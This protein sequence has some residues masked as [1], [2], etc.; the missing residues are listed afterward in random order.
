MGGTSGQNYDISDTTGTL[1]SG[2]R[3]DKDVTTIVGTPIPSGKIDI[4]GVIGQYKYSAPYNNGYQ[5]F[6][7]FISDIIDYG[8][9]L[10]LSPV[11]AADIDTNTFTVYFTT[12]RNGDTKIKYGLTKSLELD[13]LVINNDTTKHVVKVTGLLSSKTYYYRVYS[14]NS[15]G[16]S[17]S[18]F[19][20]S[21]NSF[22]QPFFRNDKYLFQFSC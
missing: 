15:K 8:A 12:A 17:E 22:F 3:I 4:I 5:L 18:D 9:P 10:I 20:F 7:R 21:Y 13:S 11:L 1:T 6:P 14:S 2:L 16:V 19:K